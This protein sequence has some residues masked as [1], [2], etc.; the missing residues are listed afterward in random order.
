MVDWLDGFQE[1]HVVKGD[2]DIFRSPQGLYSFIN[3]ECSFFEFFKEL[4]FGLRASIRRKFALFIGKK[5]V[6]LA[7]RDFHQY[8]LAFHARLLWLAITCFYDRENIVGKFFHGKPII[9]LQNPFYY[10]SIEPGQSAKWLSLYPNFQMIMMIRNPYHQLDDVLASNQLVHT[11]D[12]PFRSGTHQLSPASRFAELN[13]RVFE[14]RK[15][16]I[17][18]FPGKVMVIRFETFVADPAV[19][20]TIAEFLGLEGESQFDIAKSISNAERR[21]SNEAQEF[22]DDNPEILESV[23]RMNEIL[24]QMP[25]Q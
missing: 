19:R 14:G 18:R 1:C 4:C 17:E 13:R 8:S 7:S 20:Q 5:G 24:C 9:A 23:T 16:M 2:L 22:V 15:D 25:T 12:T 11:K 6:L 21:I 3:R 10:D